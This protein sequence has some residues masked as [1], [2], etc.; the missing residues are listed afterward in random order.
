[1]FL[2]FVTIA[3]FLV[4]LIDLAPTIVIG[5]LFPA[6]CCLYSSSRR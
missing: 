2:P 6:Y 5:V 3:V 1:M 4:G